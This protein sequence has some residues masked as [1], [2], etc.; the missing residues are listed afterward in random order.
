MGKLFKLCPAEKKE[1]QEKVKEFFHLWDLRVLVG[2]SS[3]SPGGFLAGFWRVFLR[4]LSGGFHG[5]FGKC[6]EVGEW[7]NCSNCALQRRQEKT[8]KL[9]KLCP[10][11]KTGKTGK[12]FMKSTIYPENIFELRKMKEFPVFPWGFFDFVVLLPFFGMVF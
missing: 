1:K 2:F 10:A 3:L 4:L 6:K 12:L 11:E 5:F 9:F 8:G 7:G